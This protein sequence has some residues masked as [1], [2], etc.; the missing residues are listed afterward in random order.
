[1][2]NPLKYLT[3]A[4]SDDILMQCVEQPDQFKVEARKYTE[5]FAM[6]EVCI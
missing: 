6:S 3:D 2:E 1:M 5:K 4:I